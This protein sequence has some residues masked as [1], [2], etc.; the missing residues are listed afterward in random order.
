M[1]RSTDELAPHHIC[2]YLFEL[3][4]EFNRFYEKSRVIGSEDEAARLWL[5]ERYADTLRAGLGLLG[6]ESPDAM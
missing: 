4:Q 1:E 3:A 5:V 6:I 2:N